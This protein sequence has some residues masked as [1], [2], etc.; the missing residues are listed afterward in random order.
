LNNL[1]VFFCFLHKLKDKE[2]L[3]GNW[4]LEIRQR[5]NDIS[6]MVEK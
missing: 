4:K 3:V 6:C 2:T 5:M 1:R